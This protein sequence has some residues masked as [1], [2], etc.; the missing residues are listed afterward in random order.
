MTP[1][2]RFAAAVAYVVLYLP[3]LLFAA[4]YPRPRGVLSRGWAS[5]LALLVLGSWWWH[6]RRAGRRPPV[7]GQGADGPTSTGTP[8]GPATVHH[9]RPPGVRRT[10]RT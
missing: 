9:A 8:A 7:R 5:G 10:S 3:L 2:E 4:S 6:H 1:G